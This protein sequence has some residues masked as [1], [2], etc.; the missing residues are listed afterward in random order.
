MERRSSLC[1]LGQKHYSRGEAA[2]VLALGHLPIQSSHIRYWIFYGLSSSNSR[3]NSARTFRSASVRATTPAPRRASSRHKR[4]ALAQGRS[5]CRRGERRICILGGQDD[6]TWTH[7]QIAR[8]V[9]V[10]RLPNAR[11]HAC[12]PYHRL[13]TSPCRN[14]AS[15]NTEGSSQCNRSC[16]PAAS[17]EYRG[18]RL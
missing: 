17:E 9:T 6:P 12:I 16:Q 3:P 18:N 11:H 7:D 5:G 4:L 10:Y 14:R 1:A 13:P 8:L 2:H 15:P